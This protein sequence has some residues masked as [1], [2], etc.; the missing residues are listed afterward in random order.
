MPEL[1]YSAP[2]R[3]QALLCGA[4]HCPRAREAW[5]L[6]NELRRTADTLLADALIS[7]S[8]SLP[9][10]AA[11]DGWLVRITVKRSE[12]GIE[13]VLNCQNAID[14]ASQRWSAA[15]FLGWRLLA[16]ARPDTR[17][18][19]AARE[20]RRSQREAVVASLLRCPEP[21]AA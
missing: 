14:R 5:E 2:E 1:A 7:V 17:A 11:P 6:A 13:D 12:L 10:T 8:P 9:G 21:K 3:E 16:G 20:E 15:R 4:S 19:P 18:I